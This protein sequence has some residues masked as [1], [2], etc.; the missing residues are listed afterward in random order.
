[1]ES[2]HVSASAMQRLAKVFSWAMPSASVVFSMVALG[3]R[4]AGDRVGMQEVSSAIAPI[5]ADAKRAAASSLH[6]ESLIDVHTAQ[7]AAAWAEVVAM[8]AEL[9]VYRSYSNQPAAR[10]G[11]L[12]DQATSFYRARFA[13]QIEKRPTNP[14]EAARLAL[15]QQWRPGQ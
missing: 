6:C 5:A 3:W 8:H 14:G 4:W 15:L 12:I 10:R 7:L 11:E 1:M 2:L 9:K 13:E